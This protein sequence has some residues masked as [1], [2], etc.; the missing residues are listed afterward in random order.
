MPINQVVSVWPQIH[1]FCDNCWNDCCNDAGFV[2]LS[3][4][5]RQRILEKAQRRYGRGYAASICR[6]GGY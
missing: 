2:L 1:I 5:L 4:D 6:G 3:C